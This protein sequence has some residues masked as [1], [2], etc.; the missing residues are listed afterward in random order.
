MATDL[1][2]SVS[3][4]LAGLVAEGETVVN[5]V[6]FRKRFLSG[7]HEGGPHVHRYRLDRLTL[8]LIEGARQELLGRFERAIL[9]NLEHPLLKRV[10]E[11]GDVFVAFLKALFIQR[12]VRE[13]FITV[14]SL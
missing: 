6:R 10:A 8:S 14:S 2:A 4:V 11:N 1:R 7:S 5:R 3:L 9:D 13:L 12:Q